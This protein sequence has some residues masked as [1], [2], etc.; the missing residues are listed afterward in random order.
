MSASWLVVV[1]LVSL[2][3]GVQA[4]PVLVVWNTEMLDN[5]EKASI[6]TNG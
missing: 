1:G 4:Q 3:L 5:V 2:L 6:F